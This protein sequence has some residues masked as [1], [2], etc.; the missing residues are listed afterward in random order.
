MVIPCRFERNPEI[1]SKNLIWPQKHDV[2]LARMFHKN[3]CVPVGAT[4]AAINCGD[5]ANAGIAAKADPT[6]GLIEF[7]KC[8]G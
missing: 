7:M 2:A 4:L 8:P 1:Y 6:M 5:T 3:G